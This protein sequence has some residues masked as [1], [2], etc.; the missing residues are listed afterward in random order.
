MQKQ[1]IKYRITYI[2]TIIFFM[3]ASIFYRQPFCVIMLAVLFVLP[4]ISIWLTKIFSKKISIDYICKTPSVVV[5]NDIILEI[6]LDNPTFFSFLNCELSF[7]YSNLFYPND[8]IHTLSIS[9]P[10][11]KKN[12][13]IFS[14]STSLSGIDEISF[15]DFRITDPLHLYTYVYK[16]SR[17]FNISV[18]PQ[19]ENKKYSIFAE[20]FLDTEND[21]ISV[22][23]GS[24]NQELKE[25]REYRPG[26]RLQN[27][28]WKLSSK[29]DELMV[30]EF[31]ESASRILCILPELSKEYLEDTL[32]TLW[33]Y[34]N[35]LIKSNQF[36]GICIVNYASATIDYFLI[37]NVTEAMD[38]LLKLFYMPSYENV[39]YG[40]SVFKKLY[41]EENNVIQVIGKDLILK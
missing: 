7:K 6:T 32:S 37:T 30:K 41:G 28:H 29:L 11:K 21:D 14:L 15:F 13:C 23:K 25:I 5:K 24:L 39:N 19:L 35:F 33:S 12:P 3:I 40:L 36:F 20:S 8:N 10:I 34:M 26:D 2:L 1:N 17:T 22:T 9:A 4:L 31:Q 18:I 16:S 38:A 27:I